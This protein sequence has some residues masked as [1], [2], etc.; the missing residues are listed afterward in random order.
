MEIVPEKMTF[1][2][3]TAIREE[4]GALETDIGNLVQ[5]TE[6]E[7]SPQDQIRAK[8][9]I[10]PEAKTTMTNVDYVGRRAIGQRTAVTVLLVEVLPTLNETPL[11]IKERKKPK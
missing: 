11:G 2:E 9:M 1:E 10:I 5:D 4:R 8:E 3:T 6:Q 7:I